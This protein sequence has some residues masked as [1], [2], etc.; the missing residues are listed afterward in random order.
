MKKTC[1]NCVYY[2]GCLGEE[3]NFYHIHDYCAAWDRTNTCPTYSLIN[4]FLA[5]YD[6]TG[7]CIFDDNETGES[8]CYRF[9]PV[10]KQDEKLNDDWM[11]KNFEHNKATAL[12][13]LDKIIREKKCYNSIWGKEEKLNDDELVYFRGLR[14]K[15]EDLNWEDDKNGDENSK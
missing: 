13:V 6:T 12:E 9:S 8:G 14:E 4:S 10:E 15:I 1:I 3:E 7:I 2:H 11:K 5:D